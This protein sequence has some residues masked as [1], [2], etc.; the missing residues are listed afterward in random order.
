MIVKKMNIADDVLEYLKTCRVDGAKLYLPEGQL[1]R[2]FYDK[3]DKVLKMMG[4]KWSKLMKCHIFPAD[5]S[6]V[7]GGVLEAGTVVDEKQTFQFFPTPEEVVRELLI[8]ASVETGHW[9]LEP[10][11]GDG[12][13]IKMLP[14]GINLVAVE[15]HQER[16]K[17]LAALDVGAVITADFLELE[18][19]RYKP[20]DRIV[21][22]PPFTRGAA[23]A[24]IL[25]ALKFLKPGGRLV[26]IVPGRG[27]AKLRARLAICGDVEFMVRPLPAG[28][29]KAAGTGI[30][31]SIIV[32]DSL[33]NGR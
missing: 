28:S 17:G 1:D 21:M 3:V 23:T 5:V 2:K 4:G 15:I 8:H 29:F 18:P 9:V 13:I 11:A 16:A 26:S 31:T 22:N 7:F 10:S 20:F 24:H 33:L 27:D 30:D 12:A 32:I 14:A 25:H 6:E 19:S